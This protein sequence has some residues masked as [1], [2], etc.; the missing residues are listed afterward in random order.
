[1]AR[2]YDAKQ[3]DS[4]Y[5]EFIC[6]GVFNEIAEYYP[7]YRSRYETLIKRYCDLAPPTPL[8]VLDIGGGQLGLLCKKLWND[9]AYV[10]DIGG[11][12]LDYLQEKGLK[13]V[14]WNLCLNEQPFKE[15]F[16]LIF[17]SEVIEHLPMPVH[18]AL[19]RLKI[20]L[21]PGGTI[22]CS[23]PNLYR[24]RNVIYM[25]LGK[26]IYDYFRIPEEQGLGHVIEYSIA[27]LQW[28]FEKAGLENC[29]IEYCQMLHS[30]N[31]PI[32]SMMYW[33]GSPL[34]LIPRFRDNL[35]A[36]AQRPQ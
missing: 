23:T 8:K 14:K 6:K 10:A 32:F 4:V 18:M 34:F 17:F 5:V 33:M 22:I 19:E 12:H 26:Q 21:K 15:E 30:P 25:I 3:F 11:I 2:I 1:M 35:V 29:H 36:I 28:Q 27:H 24:L 20:A 9:D 7:R 31:N 13:T 16:D